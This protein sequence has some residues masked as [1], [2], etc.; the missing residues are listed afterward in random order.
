MYPSEP[1][2]AKLSSRPMSEAA[3]S[4]LAAVQGI[5]VGHWTDSQSATG[6]TVTLAPPGGM[7]AACAVRGRASGTRELDAL[8][9]RHLVG[10]IDAVLLTGG[11][12]YGLGAAD[13]VMRWL[14]GRGGGFP[15]GPAGVVPI[16]PTAVIFDFDLAPG[17]KADRWP[18]ADDAYRACAAAA[19]AIPEGSVGAGTGATVGKALGPR[20]AMK[21]GVGTWAA[22]AGDVVVGALVVLNAVGN[23]LDANGRVLA[24]AR[25]ADGRFVDALGYL[26]QGG[27]PFAR[28]GAGQN[29]TLAVVATNAR[30]DR[31]A[32][33]A[34]AHVAGD[35]LAALRR[36]AAGER[37]AA[38]IRLLPDSSVGDEQAAVVT[39]AAAPLVREPRVNADRVSEALHGE[40]LEVLE[41]RTDTWLR[42]RAAD[43]YLAWVHPGYVALGTAA[44]AEDWAARASVRSLRADLRCQGERFRLAARRRGGA[45]AAR[46][47]GASRTWCCG[48][49]WDG[50]GT[51]PYR[52]AASSRTACSPIRRR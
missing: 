2:Q 7:R 42:V 33:Q 12:A 52:A 5:T 38:D 8:D 47:A 50:S 27:A 51:R 41:R 28:G 17:A 49:A 34:L 39:A 11:S 44:W 13:G 10:H 19:T 24:G 30:L 36:I 25:G 15:V 43:G 48:P 26:A 31:V 20:G 32:L 37:L 40:T 14:R 21:G 3:P 18:G 6:C 46:P 23:V 35:A 16:V 29:T 22:R 9:P 4:N 1:E 45:A